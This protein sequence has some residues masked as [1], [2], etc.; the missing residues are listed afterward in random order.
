MPS[1]RWLNNRLNECSYPQCGNQIGYVLVLRS[2]NSDRDS[3]FSYWIHYLASSV[4]VEIPRWS[5]KYPNYKTVSME[6]I[7]SLQERFKHGSALNFF[8]VYELSIDLLL[9]VI[10][11]NMC[12]I[13]QKKRK[14]RASARQ[15]KINRVI[16]RNYLHTSN[17]LKL[18][19]NDGFTETSGLKLFY[20]NLCQCDHKF[21]HHN[22]EIHSVNTKMENFRWKLFRV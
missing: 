16:C 9:P 15:W 17:K 5:Q 12:N 1:K 7:M 10:A 2:K 19:L 8:G 20:M 4:E 22:S 14:K 13:K 6:C 21:N 3:N 18:W 11:Q